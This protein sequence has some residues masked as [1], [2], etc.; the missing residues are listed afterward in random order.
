M[1]T[2]TGIVDKTLLKSSHLHRLHGSQH[3]CPLCIWGR[4]VRGRHRANGPAL[5]V[6][7]PVAGSH[8]LSTG[9]RV[10]PQDLLSILVDDRRGEHP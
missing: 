3:R 2:V 5:G 9:V 7:T 10:E 4:G 8:A 1:A 6:W